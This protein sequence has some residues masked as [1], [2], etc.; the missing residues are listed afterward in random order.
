MQ[1]QGL[2]VLPGFLLV[3][4]IV[5]SGSPALAAT[6]Y[7]TLTA[8][9]V[10]MSSS[11]SSGTGSSSITLA[12]VNGYTGSVQV[13]CTPPTLATSVKAPYCTNAGGGGGEV[14]VVP[15][16]KLTA[17]AAVTGTIALYNFPL[18]CS[19]PCPVSLPHRGGHGLAAGL[20]LAGALLLGFGFRRRATRWLSLTLLVAGALTGLGG[21]S[22]CGGNSDV[23]TSGTYAY[24][25]TATDVNTTAVVTTS[26]NVTVP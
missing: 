18:P 15:P 1:R 13:V 3:F 8:T 25:I 22:A 9:N 16:Y 10:T 17:N 11:G 21:I 6:P 20:A 7:F 14:P 26:M 5:V 12:S 2:I 19:N 24:T 4:G 23:V